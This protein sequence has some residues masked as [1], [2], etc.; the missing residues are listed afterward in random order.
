MKI[1]DYWED[2]DVYHVSLRVDKENSEINKTVAV[3]AGMSEKDIVDVI[4]N[5]N[6]K[7]VGVNTIDL[8]DEALLTKNYNYSKSPSLLSA[9]K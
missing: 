9:K 2:I 1:E 6:S 5:Q 7:V 8:L 3:P 4:C